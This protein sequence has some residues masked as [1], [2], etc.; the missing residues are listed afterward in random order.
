MHASE[1]QLICRYFSGH[2]KNPDGS[3][4]FK[5]GKTKVGDA[6]DGAIKIV[7][8]AVCALINTRLLEHA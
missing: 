7:T 4:Q 3:L 1:W 8:V 5:A 6:I 2:T